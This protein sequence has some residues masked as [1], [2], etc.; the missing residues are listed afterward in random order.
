MSWK[1]MKEEAKSTDVNKWSEGKKTIKQIITFKGG[2]KTTFKGVKPETIEQG[3]FTHFETEDG[4]L[5]LIND[6]NVFCVEVIK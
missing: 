6:N 4:R 1:I 3:K 2:Y 5:V